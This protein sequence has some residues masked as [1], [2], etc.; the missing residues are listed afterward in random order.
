M[1]ISVCMATYNGEKF[2]KEQVDSIL[3]QLSSKDELI[4]SDDNSQDRTLDII[5][6]YKDERIKIF[7]NIGNHG[8][9]GNFENALRNATGDYIFL[10]DQDDIWLPNKVQVVLEKL[11]DYDLIMH[12]GK[13]VDAEAHDLGRT[14]YST[15]HDKTGFWYNVWKNRFSGSRMAFTKEVLQASLPFPKCILVHDYWIGTLALKCFRVSFIPN[16][17]MLYRRHGANASSS[18]EKSRLSL[19]VKIT[20]R[21]SL[22]MAIYS[23]VFSRK[24]HK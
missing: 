17:L 2:I 19:Y 24:L 20:Y 21:L 5:R 13:I 22:L 3:S 9:K 18:S 4:V 7:S 6:S 14:C 23:R 12:D 8:F 1:R 11:K 10:S 16:I 15:L